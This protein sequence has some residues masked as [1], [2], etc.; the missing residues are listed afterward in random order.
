MQ[1]KQND[2]GT[3]STKIRDLFSRESCRFYH[4]FPQIRSIALLKKSL[5]FVDFVPFKTLGAVQI[6]AI[7]KLK[8]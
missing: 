1:I 4:Q 3:L 5:R 6:N 7:M 8:R 2:Q